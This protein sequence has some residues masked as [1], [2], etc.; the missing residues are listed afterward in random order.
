VVPMPMFPAVSIRNLSILLVSKAKLLRSFVPKV[1]KPPKELP[2]FKKA[3]LPRF[4]VVV[5]IDPPRLEVKRVVVV[6][7]DKVLGTERLVIVALVE[8]KLVL[9][10]V[11]LTKV[12]AVAFVAVKLV[13][14]PV[15]TFNNVAKKL[16]EVALVLIK[17]VVVAVP[18]ILIPP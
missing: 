15:T 7:K 10:K 18:K 3:K 6:A 8:V 17:L 9:V 2:L 16:E 14:K 4:K 11:V 12:V 1:A 5:A 13:K